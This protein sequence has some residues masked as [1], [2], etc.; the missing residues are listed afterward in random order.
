[1]YIS[2]GEGQ[3]TALLTITGDWD[4]QSIVLKETFPQLTDDD[5]LFESGKE[6]ELL[7]RVE[8]RLNKPREEII[9]I[10]YKTHTD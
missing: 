5:L 10:I 9:D 7:A 4:I 3:K 8:S 6:A 2:H 1:M